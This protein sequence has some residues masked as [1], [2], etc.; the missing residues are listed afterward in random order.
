MGMFLILQVWRALLEVL[1]TVSLMRSW[2]IRTAA[3]A[4]GSSPRLH[5]CPLRGFQAPDIFA[6]N[7]SEK[8]KMSTE[9][10]PKTEMRSFRQL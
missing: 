6:L 2:D 10:S 3:A 4:Q 8:R 9:P 7:L 5:P 1:G